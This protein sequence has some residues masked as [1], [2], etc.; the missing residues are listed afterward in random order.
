MQ[1]FKLLVFT[2]TM[3]SLIA[4]QPSG[5]S[6]QAESPDSVS[7][8]QSNLPANAASFTLP[9]PQPE[10][11]VSEDGQ[12]I[13]KASPSGF[14]ANGVWHCTGKMAKVNETIG[15]DPDCVGF[16]MEFKD[17]G[18]LSSGHYGTTERTGQ[19]AFG[20]ETIEIIYADEADRLYGY[21]LQYGSN[22]MIFLGNAKYNTNPM[23]M[24]LERYDDYPTPP[25]Q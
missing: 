5:N 1:R 17:D 6:S 25:V 2:I 14:L 13:H 11:E 7:G 8:A 20:N 4:C 18:T 15:A 24:K 22:A 21:R 9:R 10:T 19:W 3:T 16:W 23:Q 12:V